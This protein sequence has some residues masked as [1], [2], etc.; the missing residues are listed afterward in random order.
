MRSRLL[1]LLAQLLQAA[2][3]KARARAPATSQ[4]PFSVK[5]VER[6]S[7]HQSRFSSTQLKGEFMCQINPQE[8]V[9]TWNSGHE[10]F[11][12]STEEIKPLTEEEKRAKLAEM[13]KARDERKALQ[14]LKDK[15]EAKKNEVCHTS[16]KHPSAQY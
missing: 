12:Q 3:L 1:I 10:Q 11:A 4:I 8:N 14:A 7:G 16:P 13:M 5:N 2:L 15:E 6:N 9:L